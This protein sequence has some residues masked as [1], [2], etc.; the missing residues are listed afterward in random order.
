MEGHTLVERHYS[1]VSRIVYPMQVLIIPFLTGG[2]ALDQYWYPSIS[3]IGRDNDARYRT[4]YGHE[5]IGRHSRWVLSHGDCAAAECWTSTLSLCIKIIAAIVLGY[6]NCTIQHLTAPSGQIQACLQMER[7]S[8]GKRFD[9]TRILNTY[10]PKSA[11]FQAVQ[12]ERDD[13]LFD[14]SICV[15]CNGIRDQCR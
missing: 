13:E 5:S 9:R 2:L 8:Q 10:H 6:S 11:N 14:S 4:S 3:S 1:L 12:S 7:N 15:W